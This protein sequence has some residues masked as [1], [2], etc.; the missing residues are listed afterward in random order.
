MR[1]VFLSMFLG[2][3][4]VVGFAET[5]MVEGHGSVTSSEGY[6]KYTQ[7][8]LLGAQKE[9][10]ENARRTCEKKDGVLGYQQG[11]WD[12]DAYTSPYMD[13]WT[14]VNVKGTFECL[15]QGEAKEL[16]CQVD[17]VRGNY[18]RVK[19]V[20]VVV[21][22]GSEVAEPKTV[23]LNGITVSAIFQAGDRFDPQTYLSMQLDDINT[24]VYDVKE[25]LYIMTRD[26]VRF[27]CWF[28]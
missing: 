9:A 1:V 17:D 24:I 15:L 21:I 16:R 28:E 12:V 22:H 25:S 11:R 19:T 18:D 26:K 10:T 7:K 23:V 8:D 27:Q 20:P 4:S 2:L 3:F 13:E 14:F 6:G 5:V